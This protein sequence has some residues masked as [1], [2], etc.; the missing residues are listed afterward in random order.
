MAIYCEQFLNGKKN[1][2]SKIQINI[3]KNL[4]PYFDITL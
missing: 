1:K 2:N 3:C 4:Q